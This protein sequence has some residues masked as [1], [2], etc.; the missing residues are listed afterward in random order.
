[1]LLLTSTVDVIQIVA[2]DATQLE[3]H[4]SYAD[5]AAGVVTPGR[6]NTTVTVSGTTT[7][8]TSPAQNVQRNIRTLVV[9]N[10]DPSASNNVKVEHVAET[11]TTTLWYGNLSAGEEAILSQEGTWDVYDLS[12]LEKNYNMIGATGPAGSAGGAT[13]PTGPTGA[14]GIQGIAG[15]QG[16]TGATGPTGAT[17]V[18]VSGIQGPTGVTGPSGPFGSSGPGGTI[19]VTGPTG[20]TGAQGTA[21]TGPTGAT[22]ATGATG[23]TGAVGSTGPTGAN[24]P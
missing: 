15:P 12:G 21:F 7:V 22:G 23:P 20:A 1:M 10:D 13:G 8:V 6:Q 19:G 24:T 3:I 17:G 5:N 2:T 14:T 9:R 11:S 4:A 18:A 16:V